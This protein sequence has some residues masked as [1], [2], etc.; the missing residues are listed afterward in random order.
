MF[1]EKIQS[2]TAFPQ[3]LIYHFVAETPEKD[4]KKIFESYYVPSFMQF[5]DVLDTYLD[6]QNRLIP[7]LQERNIAEVEPMKWQEILLGIN[8]SIIKTL[9]NHMHFHAG[10]YRDGGMVI[11]R[12]SS[13]ELQYILLFLANQIPVDRAGFL[14]LMEEQFEQA[15]KI[16][17]DFL[18]LISSMQTRTDIEL[19]PSSLAAIGGSREQIRITTLLERLNTA[20]ITDVLTEEQKKVVEEVMVPCIFP[21]ELSGLMDAFYLEL[22]A[23]LASLDKANAHAVAELMA[24]V[25]Y[26]IIKIHPFANGNGRTAM[27]FI[28]LLLKQLGYPPI[29]F[30]YSL[31]K[32]DDASD[33]GIATNS[34]FKNREP[35][36]QL[37]LKRFEETIP[38]DERGFE[39]T[40]VYI[41]LSEFLLQKHQENPDRSI[42]SIFLEVNRIARIKLGMPQKVQLSL[43]DSLRLF[44]EIPQLT[45]APSRESIFSVA[46]AAPNVSELL[47]QYHP[48]N[49][50]WKFYNKN[51]SAL[52]ICESKEQ[53]REIAK[54]LNDA[55]L[56]KAVVSLIKATSQP[57]VQVT[58]I[59][60]EELVKQSLR[61]KI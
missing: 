14:E 55:G 13:E 19:R 11:S 24:D 10:A 29:C 22:Q 1:I 32:H 8:G 50:S 23:Q 51:Q 59:Q 34:I 33:Y 15:P 36:V 6:L 42:D 31:E 53:A 49:N 25:F 30:Y 3:A 54:T 38:H 9:A 57:V 39:K 41:Q 21:E 5:N 52:L 16:Y 12:R 26:R 44:Q 17:D 43:E 45:E 58:E 47:N 20:Y 46:S 18:S 4:E 56:M 60:I 37:I 61:L 27:C 2:L 7:E 28:N 35:M 40:R 48:H